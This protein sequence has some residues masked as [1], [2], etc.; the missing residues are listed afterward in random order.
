M[1]LDSL[2][3]HYLKLIRSIDEKTL[4]ADFAE[5]QKQVPHKYLTG[6]LN[7]AN[8]VDEGEEILI[9]AEEF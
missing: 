7:Q 9:L 5:L 2:P 3:A 8:K 1:K 6:L 4:N